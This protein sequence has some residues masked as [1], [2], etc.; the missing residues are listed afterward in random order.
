VSARFDS[1]PV[2]ALQRARRREILDHL[3]EKNGF[4][5][6]RREPGQLPL[7]PLRMVEIVI[8][9]LAKDIA[10]RTLNADVST[11]SEIELAR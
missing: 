11:L 1:F 2:R 8:V 6:T 5:I 7:E 9:P 10:G 4:M 3:T